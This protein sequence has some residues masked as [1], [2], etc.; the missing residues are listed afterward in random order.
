V[1]VHVCAQVLLVMVKPSND[2]SAPKLLGSHANQRET[3]DACSGERRSYADAS[4]ECLSISETAGI[5]ARQV[6]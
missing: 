6:L 4:A 5:V 3:I 1:Q 2:E